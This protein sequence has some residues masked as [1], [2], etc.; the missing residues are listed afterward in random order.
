MFADSQ[1]EEQLTLRSQQRIVATVE[2]SVL[3]TKMSDLESQ[4]EDA[5]T[6]ILFFKS[7]SWLGQIRS[8]HRDETWSALNT[9]TAYS[10]AK[11][12]HDWMVDQIAYLFRTTHRVKT[13][14][15]VKIR[16]Q[17]CGEVELAGYLE[18]AV[19]H[20]YCISVLPTTEL[21]VV[22]TLLLTDT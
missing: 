11:K 16:G 5:P 7:M 19:G 2:D 15:V 9:C 3:R 14:Q 21:G 22:L 12:A 1:R 18:N 10:G 8:H 4:E 6:C 13:Q 20:W 17:H